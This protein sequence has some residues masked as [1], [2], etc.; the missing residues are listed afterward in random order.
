MVVMERPEI[1][2]NLVNEVDE[3]DEVDEVDDKVGK[4]EQHTWFP[5]LSYLS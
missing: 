2:I 5:L 4:E 3:M 1:R